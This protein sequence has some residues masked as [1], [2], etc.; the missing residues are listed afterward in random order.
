MPFII[1]KCKVMHLTRN[2]QHYKYY[3]ANQPLGEVEEEINLGMHIACDLKSSRQC[4]LLAYNKMIKILA[5]I[6]RTICYKNTCVLLSLYKSLARTL[7]TRIY[8]SG[9]GSAL[10]EDKLLLER[11]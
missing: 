3:L 5:A 1:K 2:H 6:N 4:L 9:S 11:A 10:C 8:D 7:R